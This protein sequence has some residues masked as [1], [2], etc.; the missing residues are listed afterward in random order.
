[1]RGH[2]IANCL[3]VLAVNRCGTEDAITF[4]GGSFLAG[5]M[6]EILAE[7]GLDEGILEADLDLAAIDRARMLSPFLRDRR[8]D[9]YGPL[10]TRGGGPAR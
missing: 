8:T 4:Y 6:G 5:P 3:A 2:A 10:L 7:P 9:T 1:M